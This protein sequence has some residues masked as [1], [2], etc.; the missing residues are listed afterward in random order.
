[1]SQ[2]KQVL[3]ILGLMAA[4]AGIALQHRWLVWTAIGLLGASMVI[5]MILGAKARRDEEP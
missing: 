5:R 1:M 2:L 4:M 3:G